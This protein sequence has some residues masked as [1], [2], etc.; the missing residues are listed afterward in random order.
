MP[1]DNNTIKVDALKDLPLAVIILAAGL[2]KRMKSSKP[3]V[4]HEI[5]G[6]PLITYAIHAAQYLNPSK[7]CVVV[8]HGAEE[9]KAK[10]AGL[11]GVCFALQSAPLGT[12]HA[13]LA[14]LEVLKEHEGLVLILPGDVPL[15]SPQ[16]L[17][18]FLLAHKT[19]ESDLSVL[20]VELDNPEAYGRIIRDSGGWLDRI[21]EFK[22]ATS[23][24]RDILEIN[25]GIYLTEAK[26]LYPALESLDNNNAQ[27]EYYLT[28]IVAIVKA[29][30]KLCSAIL[31]PDSGEVQG[32]NDRVDLYRCQETL[33][34]KINE[35]WLRA[36]VTMA[37]PYSTHIESQVKLEKDVV[38]GPGVV[39][40]GSTKVSEGATIGPYA[41]IKDTFIEKGRVILPHAVLVN[42]KAPKGDEESSVCL[43]TNETSKAKPFVPKMRKRATAATKGANKGK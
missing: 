4:L 23:Y 16:T 28:D 8:G 38:L 42:G 3:K 39:L 22:D 19:L 2:G 35:S 31:S 7:I 26:E 14:S 29:K 11:K 10:V 12:G 37:D 18:D 41:V 9:V 30:G 33:R 21:V 27:E 34:L 32:V 24:E 13:T 5:L 17:L 43:K 40:L 36:G 20:T 1:D 6:R 15:I 25:S